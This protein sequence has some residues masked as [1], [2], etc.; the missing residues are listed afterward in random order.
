MSSGEKPSD[1]KTPPPATA[2]LA[3]EFT[4]AQVSSM[5]GTK[6]AELEEASVLDAHVPAGSFEAAEAFLGS[7]DGHVFKMGDRGL[8]YYSDERKKLYTALEKAE[9]KMFPK[10]ALERKAEGVRALQPAAAPADPEPEGDRYTVEFT[11][12]KWGIAAR[13]TGGP[14]ALTKV[15]EG[16]EG[17]ELGLEVGDVMVEVNGVKFAENRGVAL[18]MIRKG[19]PAKLTLVRPTKAAPSAAPIPTGVGSGAD[20]TKSLAGSEVV[21]TSVRELQAMIGGAKAKD[22]VTVAGQAGVTKTIE[23]DSFGHNSTLV[24]FNCTDCVYTVE[25]YSLKVYL[26]G[27]KN[28]KVVFNGKILT[29]TLEAFKCENL[30][31][32]LNT[33]CGTL[34]ADMCDGLAITYAKREMFTMIVW[35]GCERIKVGFG[36][37]KQ[38]LESG[39][40]EMAAGNATVNKERSQFKISAVGGRIL[41]EPVIRLANG[42]TTTM[43]EK[44]IFDDNQER[45]VQ[46]MAKT[47]GITIRPKKKGIKC[48]PNDP[49]PCGSGRKVKKCCGTDANGYYI[50]PPDDAVPTGGSAVSS[51]F[52]GTASAPASEE[53]TEESGK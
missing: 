15:K 14:V 3:P 26:Q 12:P 30:D 33:K 24:F 39:F 41:Q 20:T 4:P 7:R 31:V 2:D 28:V 45:A 51:S 44:K 34:Q 29:S 9:A 8:G 13:M 32:T 37:D 11:K 1:A 21:P 35:A 52:L 38:T 43:R 16:G 23:A 47:M 46:A 40:A 48:K 42:F 22:T 6:I 25:A 49:C 53:A 27:C 5:I 18:S 50:P 36:D 19:G 17:L 10:A